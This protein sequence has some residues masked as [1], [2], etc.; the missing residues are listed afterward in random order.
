[1]LVVCSSALILVGVPSTDS[2][3]QRMTDFHYLKCVL[4]MPVLKVF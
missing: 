4:C 1:M 2:K 3:C